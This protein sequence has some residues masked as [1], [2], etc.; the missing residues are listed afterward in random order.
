MLPLSSCTHNLLEDVRAFDPDMSFISLDRRV[1]DR[2]G[3]MPRE[4]GVEATG[5]LFDGYPVEAPFVA[6]D[7]PFQYVG[8]DDGN[9]VSYTC[10]RIQMDAF[11]YGGHSGGGVFHFTNGAFTIQG[12]NSTSN[13]AGSATAT[14]FTAQNNADLL[15]AIANGEAVRPP[16]DR[17]EVIEYV[18]NDASKGLVDTSVAAG[19]S[20]TFTLNA[21]NAGYI[22]SRATGGSVYLTKFP[23]EHDFATSVG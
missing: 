23:F 18:F 16:V 19:N 15:N 9:V 6:P 22:P 8:F 13:R 5:L 11:T 20:F 17:A 14:R 21:F 1:G 12:V 2:T 3:W 7:N 10:C 4:W